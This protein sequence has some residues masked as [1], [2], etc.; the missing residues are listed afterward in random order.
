[1]Q[2]RATLTPIAAALF[3]LRWWNTPRSLGRTHMSVP[4]FIYSTASHTAKLKLRRK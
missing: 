1:M 4:T 2:F 3:N